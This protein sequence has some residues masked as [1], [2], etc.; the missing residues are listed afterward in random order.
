MITCVPEHVCVQ[1]EIFSSHFE[2]H[3]PSDARGD[4]SQWTPLREI[5]NLRRVI[6]IEFP[7]IYL[8]N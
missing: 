8:N 5:T 3:G 4:Y 7:F 2:N 6:I 1:R